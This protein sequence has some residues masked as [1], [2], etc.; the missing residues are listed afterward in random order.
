MYAGM[1]GAEFPNFGG[2]WPRNFGG[3][4]KNF[5]GEEHYSVII[6]DGS[7]S[8]VR[9]IIIKMAYYRARESGSRSRRR[10][11]RAW[12]AISF[13]EPGVKFL[14]S[15]IGCCTGCRG[16][17]NRETRNICRAPS[18]FRGF[19]RPAVDRQNNEVAAVGETR[20]FVV[21]VFWPRFRLWRRRS[22][23]FP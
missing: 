1:H 13:N 2:T 16:P 12:P 4:A 5:G 15:M 22:G 6:G 9:G 19:I 18:R 7:R 21:P 20:R 3:P 10:N 17:G 23:R 8:T 14:F 11:Y